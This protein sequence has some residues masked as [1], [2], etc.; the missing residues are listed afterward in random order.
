MNSNLIFIPLSFPYS[1][2]EEYSFINNELE[3]ISQYFEKIIIYPTLITGP[4]YKIPINCEVD[5]RY[6]QFLNSI[7][8]DNLI[9]NIISG[10]LSFNF[11]SELFAN[12]NNYL[13]FK[14]ILKL[15][16]YT[17]KLEKKIKWFEKNLEF[18]TDDI[19]YT[20]WFT[21]TT[22]AIAL[23][24][25]A[26][27]LKIVTRVHGIDLYESR[28]FYNIPYRKKSLKNINLVATI[29]GKG[30]EYLSEKYHDFKYKIHC[31]YLGINNF[32]SFYTQ[33]S[34]DNILRVVSCSSVIKIKRVN[35][36]YKS[37]Y[38]VVVNH[39][40]N[41]EWTHIGG[42]ELL[43]VLK[44]EIIIHPNLKINFLNNIPHETV[45]AIYQELVVDLFIH[46]SET[47][48]LPMVM[49]EAI[50]F[51]VPIISTNVGGVSEIVAD[52]YNGYLVDKNGE[53][54]EMANKIYEYF[55]LTEYQKGLMRKNSKHLWKKKFNSNRNAL[56]FVKSILSI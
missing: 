47:E 48:G 19:I 15:A 1:I 20:F 22:N 14:K 5:I 52:G 16:I 37:L 55:K 35:L 4:V 3:I 18:D 27:K 8:N 40:I 9:C 21:D 13:S 33:C 36:I 50:S 26:R 2:G 45:I 32:S 10:I 30:Q 53:I 17:S 6:G 51:G 24:K 54:E 25:N 46:A 38:K 44:K 29:S 12:T 28:N 49:I 11:F 43:N 31:H 41:I 7:K 56:T 34:N 23:S 42:G 39:N